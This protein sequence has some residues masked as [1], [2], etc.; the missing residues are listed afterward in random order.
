M[1]LL[2]T[3]EEIIMLIGWVV[4]LPFGFIGFLNG[5]YAE[6]TFS[7]NAPCIAYIGGEHSEILTRNIDGGS[8]Q[9]IDHGR[10]CEY[11]I[12]ISH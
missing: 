2:N 1:I 6:Q 10:G 7:I 3:I 5:G 8:S 11:K 12:T 4:F 9:S